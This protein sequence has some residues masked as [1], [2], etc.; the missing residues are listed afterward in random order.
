M[1]VVA[2]H[3]EAICWLNHSQ[4]ARCS[5]NFPRRVHLTKN[6]TKL[7]KI[8]GRAKFCWQG[9]DVGGCIYGMGAAALVL[10][11]KQT[12]GRGRGA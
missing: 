7:G 5:A 3:V 8:W 4:P 11:A 10:V 6:F 9:A 12:D 1:S 2:T